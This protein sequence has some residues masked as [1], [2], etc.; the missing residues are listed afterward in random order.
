MRKWVKKREIRRKIYGGKERE[1]RKLR[2][3]KKGW[4]LNINRR[5]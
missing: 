5:W 3:I 1:K 4:R 2:K